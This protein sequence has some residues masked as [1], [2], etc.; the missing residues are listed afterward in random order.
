MEAI[1]AM[2]DEF[3]NTQVLRF[4]LSYKTHQIN[5][6]FNRKVTMMKL[7]KMSTAAMLASI[8][9]I[10]AVADENHHPGEDQAAASQ[11]PAAGGQMPKMN[12]QGP[13]AGMMGQQGQMPMMQ[14]MH[15]KQAMMQEHMKKTEGHLANIE[16]LLK[17]LVE[18][19]KK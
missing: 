14:M 8:I 15:Q 12:Q 7:I 4:S 9:S 13:M 19:Q 11:M 18:L 10:S 16:A 1:F 2:G 3:I 5:F 17:Q 6:N